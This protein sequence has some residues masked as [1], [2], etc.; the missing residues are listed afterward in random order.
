VG[1]GGIAHNVYA[2]DG[3][4]FNEFSAPQ[5]VCGAGGTKVQ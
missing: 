5:Q 4:A 1:K 3:W 2:L